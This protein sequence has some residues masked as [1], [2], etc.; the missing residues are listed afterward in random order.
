MPIRQHTLPVDVAQKIVQL[1]REYGL[2]YGAVDL[3]F[4][5]GAG[6]R[7][8]E[9][10]PEGQFLWVEIEAEV[11]ISKALTRCLLRVDGCS[12]SSERHASATEA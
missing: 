9:L 4:D 5:S 1:V 6:Y 7:F 12:R 2:T 8:F 10:N 11:E 3:R